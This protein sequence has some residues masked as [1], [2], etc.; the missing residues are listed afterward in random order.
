M[1]TSKARDAASQWHGALSLLRRK[2]NSLGAAIAGVQR[3][4]DHANWIEAQCLQTIVIRRGRQVD[5]LIRFMGQLSALVV[6]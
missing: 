1:L 4:L 2:N 5:R 3:A 6:A